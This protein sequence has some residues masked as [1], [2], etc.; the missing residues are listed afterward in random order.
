MKIYLSSTFMDLE[1]YRAIVGR[2]LRKAGYDVM[3]ME[4]YV[5]RDERV[6]FACKGDVV[7]CDV[8]VGIFAWRYGHIPNENNPERLSVTEMEY[9]AAGEKPM[10]RLAFLLKDKA[11]WSKARKDADLSR[12]SDLRARLK[13][14]CSAYFSSADELAVEVLAALRVHESTRLAQKIEAIDAILK[15]QEFGSSYMANIKDKLEVLRQ[16]QYIELYIEPIP[17]W[18]TRLYLVAAL[19]E[20]FGQTLGFTFIDGAGKFILMAAPSE[21]CHRLALRWPELDQVYR[22]FRQEVV[23]NE[24]LESNLWRYPLFVEQTFGKDE[25]SVKHCLLICDLEYELGI[26]RNAEV[27]D[28]REKGQ[29]FLQQEI[30]GRQ[31][32]YVALVRDGKL[33]GLVDRELLAERVAQAALQHIA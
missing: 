19:A 11:R 26:F 6:E 13:S 7:K 10:T 12:I 33:E 1:R 23:T 8:Y 21:I 31:T 17:W 14:Q 9:V 5:A 18:N 20:E 25:Q 16:V 3:M 30:L 2:A 32:R 28:V 15:S 22:N 24:Q 29:L 27:V 4:E